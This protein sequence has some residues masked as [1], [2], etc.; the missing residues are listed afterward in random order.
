MSIDRGPARGGP[1][2]RGHMGAM[3]KPVEKAK[4]F[5]GTLKRLVHYL[6]PQKV[7]FLAV[8]ILAVASTVFSIFGPKILGMATTKLA[9]GVLA[10]RVD[11]LASFDFAFIGKILLIMIF[12][13]VVSFICGYVMNY[14]MAGVSQKTVYTMR[15][16]VKD[17]L[18]R[19]SLKYFDSRTHGEIQSRITN[20]MDNIATTLQQS[21]TQLITS[22]VTVLGIL[23]MMVSISPLLTLIALVSLPINGVLTVLIAKNSQKHFIRQQKTLGELN[24]HVEEMLTGHKI[25]KAFGHERESIERFSEINEELYEAGWKA[26]FISGV[27]M[28]AL[29]LINNL[30]YVVLCILGGILVARRSIELGDIQAFIQYIR[31]FTQPI[32][33]TANIANIIQ[34]TVASAERVFEILDEEEQEPDGPMVDTF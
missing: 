17:K 23:I 1:M 20:D 26:Q 30:G 4:D 2:G 21:L 24:G 14:I 29:N 33:Q 5:K 19:L 13:Y 25:I 7:R 11:P 27:M 8:G 9:E 22:L 3:G 18:D 31:Q 10:R 6:A 34:G 32:V 12:L 15:N 28:P 16:E